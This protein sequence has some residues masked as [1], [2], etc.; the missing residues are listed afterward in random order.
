M[1][2]AINDPSDENATPLGVEA[3]KLEGSESLAQVEVLYI[4]RRGSPKLTTANMELFG[5]K[6]TP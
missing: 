2:K 5:E 1:V 4:V 6:E 3:G